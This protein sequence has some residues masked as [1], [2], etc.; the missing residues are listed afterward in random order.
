MLPATKKVEGVSY[1]SQVTA[2][3]VAANPRN[4]GLLFTQLTLPMPHFVSGSYGYIKQEDR[5]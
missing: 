2:V 1:E 5:Q 3:K 4:R